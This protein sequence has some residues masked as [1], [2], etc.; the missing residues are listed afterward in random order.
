MSF[1]LNSHASNITEHKKLHKQSTSTHK[2]KTHGHKKK[3]HGNPDGTTEVFSL[4]TDHIK[5]G[6]NDKQFNLEKNTKG[7]NLEK[8]KE[9]SKKETGFK[10]I[11]T[12]VLFV[13][14]IVIVVVVF[15]FIIAIYFNNVVYP[16]IGNLDVLNTIIQTVGAYPL[17]PPNHPMPITGTI[18][19]FDCSNDPAFSVTGSQGN[20]TTAGYYAEYTAQ[21]KN[22]Q[23][24][25]DF[26]VNYIEPTASISGGL[27][28]VFG[29]FQASFNKQI[30]G[31]GTAYCNVEVY[32]PEYEVCVPFYYPCCS[33]P[34]KSCFYEICSDTECTS[35]PSTYTDS[36]LIPAN[37]DFSISIANATVTADIQYVATNKKSLVPSDLIGQNTVV[38]TYDG[39]KFY[40]F[41][42]ILSNLQISYLEQ[43]VVINVD[44]TFGII[45]DIPS[46]DSLIE[47][48]ISSL[49]TSVNSYFTITAFNVSQY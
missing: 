15:A 49:E 16:E 19:D 27:E 6:G 46:I 40:M 32:I 33:N 39:S 18:N 36:L 22:V 30:V 48:L 47:S 7:F 26:T 38:P 20:K 14:L 25:F 28:S 42:T 24:A 29:T 4:S 9:S 3:K 31:T 8:N 5:K 13:I 23:S 17:P 2:K 11:L 41:D 44:T 10:A 43:D 1:A 34:W 45:P 35:W 37:F 12:I 21:L